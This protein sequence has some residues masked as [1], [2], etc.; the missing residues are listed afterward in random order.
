MYQKGQRI[1]ALDGAYAHV[2]DIPNALLASV[3]ILGALLLAW[4][5]E[6]AKPLPPKRPHLK[7]PRR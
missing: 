3:G 1:I 2:P 6:I 7:T 4:E 5:L